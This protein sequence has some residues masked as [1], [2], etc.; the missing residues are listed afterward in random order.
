MIFLA[1]PVS[2]SV[3]FS[4]ERCSECGADLATFAD[5]ITQ[6]SFT[7]RLKSE[8]V[9]AKAFGFIAANKLD[10]V[11]VSSA[12]ARLFFP[13][14]CRANATPSRRTSRFLEWPT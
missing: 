10:F 6:E 9:Q 7:W 13:L 5:L 8:S 3:S 11:K 2:P 12:P 1:S 4:S 14:H